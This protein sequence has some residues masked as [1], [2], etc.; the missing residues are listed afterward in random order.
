MLD[1][2]LLEFGMQIKDGIHWQEMYPGQ[3]DVGVVSKVVFKNIWG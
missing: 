1:C 3:L 2:I